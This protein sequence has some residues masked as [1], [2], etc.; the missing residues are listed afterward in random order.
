MSLPT[1]QNDPIVILLQDIRDEVRDQGA[2][3]DVLE[4]REVVPVAPTDSTAQEINAISQFIHE[5]P[6]MAVFIL[7]LLFILAVIALFVLVIPLAKRFMDNNF[8]HFGNDK[9]G[10]KITHSQVQKQQLLYEQKSYKILRKL[11]EKNGITI[12]DESAEDELVL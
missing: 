7:L 5:N 11:A 10:N 12:R 9:R 1:P 2:R 3:L 6:L 8:N 4:T